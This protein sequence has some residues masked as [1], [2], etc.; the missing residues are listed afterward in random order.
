LRCLPVGAETG[1][2]PMKRGFLTTGA[3]VIACLA[4]FVLPRFIPSSITYRGERI[5]L[6]RYYWTYEDYKD[7]SD[8]IDPTENGRVQR[9]VE[10]A[11]IAGSFRDRREIATAIVEI[12][13]PGYGS[14][15]FGGWNANSELIGFVVEIPRSSTGRYFVFRK[16]EKGYTLIDDFLDSSMSGIDHIEEKDG[17]LVYSM[18]GHPERLIRTLHLSH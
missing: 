8:N 18:T 14:G 6:T 16:N 11:P 9:L 13:F 12:A 17:S 7:D 3:V 5:K 10:E 2:S 15:G 1:V 4:W